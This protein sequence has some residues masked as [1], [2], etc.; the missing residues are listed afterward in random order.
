MKTGGE[1]TDARDYE[2]QFHGKYYVGEM[3]DPMRL[4]VLYE[5]DL[6]TCIIWMNEHLD[7]LEEKVTFI[8]LMPAM[9]DVVDDA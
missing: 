2:C 1:R 6:G 3:S 4:N 7:D 5:G 8:E 9:K